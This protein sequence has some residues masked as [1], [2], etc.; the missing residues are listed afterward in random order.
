MKKNK[1]LLVAFLLF[2]N[3]NNGFALTPT[4]TQSENE[5]GSYTVIFKSYEKTTIDGILD[6]EI[7]LTILDTIEF[8]KKFFLSVGVPTN[9]NMSSMTNSIPIDC[10]PCSFLKFQIHLRQSD[11]I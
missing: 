5:A 3:F 4:D 6:V 8:N 1:F 7:K 11:K 9:R 10:H 2:A